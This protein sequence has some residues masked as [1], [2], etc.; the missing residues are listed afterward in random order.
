MPQ[1]LRGT[2]GRT[3]PL[4]GTCINRHYGPAVFTRDYNLPNPT[5]R[6]L[7]NGS[8]NFIK[9]GWGQ[10]PH[11]QAAKFWNI[12][13]AYCNM[14][15]PALEC[16]GCRKAEGRMEPK[17]DELI[18]GNSELFCGNMQ[19]TSSALTQI[20][21]RA[22]I[23]NQQS[24]GNRMLDSIQVISGDCFP[25]VI[26]KGCPHLSKKG[27]TYCMESC[28]GVV[29]I[30]PFVQIR[31][32][33]NRPTIGQQKFIFQFQIL[34][35][36]LRMINRQMVVNAFQGLGKRA[37]AQKH[38]IDSL[39]LEVDGNFVLSNCWHKY[40]L[41]GAQHNVKCSLRFA[42]GGDANDVQ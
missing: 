22:V 5:S 26:I 35:L 25:F 18:L 38:S 37:I 15:I 9:H 16:M 29:F 24:Q 27:Q 13:N 39:L 17:C 33:L 3:E 34:P 4:M 21:G 23:A 14:R 36:G 2:R 31:A 11:Y 7:P 19:A 32:I 8:A 20:H 1:P 30:T 12:L 6:G 28:P 42:K 41:A 40:I 10:I